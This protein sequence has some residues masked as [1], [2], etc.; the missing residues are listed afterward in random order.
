MIL[1]SLLTKI[2][3]VRIINHIR[4]SFVEDFSILL[5]WVTSLVLIQHRNAFIKIA[6]QKETICLML[7]LLSHTGKQALAPPKITIQMYVITLQ[8]FPCFL[9]LN[10]FYMCPL[11]E[12]T[13][14]YFFWKRETKK[15]MFWQC[16][17]FGPDLRNYSIVQVVFTIPNR[18]GRPKREKS[19]DGWIRNGIA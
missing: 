10:D 17:F 15:L 13:R 19:Q 11:T 9:F 7:L 8:Y 14:V 4:L 5:Q 6:D 3:C 12:K 2:R 18:I 1:F 16:S